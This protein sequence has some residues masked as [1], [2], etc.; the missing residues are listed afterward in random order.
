MELQDVLNALA[1]TATQEIERESVFANLEELETKYVGRKGELTNVL[2]QLATVSAEER[3]RLGQVAN[4]VKARI[5]QA[6]AAKRAELGSA[7]RERILLEEREDISEHGT[8]FPAGHVHLVNQ[9]MQ[10]I[11]D[12]FS[13]AGFVHVQH[14]EVEWDWFTFEALNMPGDH[15]ARDEWET[16]FMDAGVHEKMGKMLLTPH[17]TSGTTHELKEQTPPIRSITMQKCYR[18]QSDVTHVPMFHQ[19]DGV[20][21]DKGV[22]LGH[23]R[24]ILDY[25]AKEFFGPTRRTRLRPYHF[26]FTE[27]S[28]EIDVTCG[29]CDGTGLVDG[30]KCRTCKRGW[31][32]LGGAGML[33]PNVLTACGLDPKEYSGLAFGWGV[34]RTY[35]M[36]SGM[37]M[38]DLRVMYQNDIRFLEQF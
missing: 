4:E 12:I 38:D 8:K 21:V 15:P 7:E 20:F 6:I 19:F 26:R 34:E 5:E 29:V 27:P 2:K 25:F 3:P 37:K 35:M 32:E 23:L 33:H 36:K 13:R 22:T 14:P 17:A 24:G 30:V 28:F 16:F 11:A 1:L 9:A 31:L 18:R 10:E